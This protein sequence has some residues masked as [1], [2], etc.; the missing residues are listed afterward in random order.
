MNVVLS[1]QTSMRNV[2]DLKIASCEKTYK[3]LLNTVSIK[4][5]DDK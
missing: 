1:V 5:I 4:N 2:V 3:R